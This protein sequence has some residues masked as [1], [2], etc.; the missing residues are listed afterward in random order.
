VVADGSD[1]RTPQIVSEFRNYGVRLLFH[2]R[3]EGKT[4]ALNRAVPASSGEILLFSDANTY[5]QPDTIEKLT[6][7]FNDPNV[8]GVS[9]RKIVL[10]DAER[11]ATEGEAAYW[12]YESSLK[13]WESLLGSIVTA[14]GEIFA[15]R[16]SLFEPIPPKTVHDDMYLTLRIIEQGYRV[17]YENEAISGEHASRTLRD[18]FH[19]KVRY[20]SAGYQIIA[21]FRHMLLPPRR[22][23]AVEFIFHKVCRWMMPFFLLGALLS[24]AII[25]PTFYQRMFW[26]QFAF[27]SI[28]VLGWALHKKVHSFIL[29]FPLYFL[30][31]NAA[32][33]CGFARHFATG[34]TTL[35]RKAE[36]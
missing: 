15:M 13:N 26:L 29:H 28:A 23:F 33:L 22:W 8:G 11:E 6:R 19:L 30:M 14:D 35:W 18:E 10:K 16:R 24:S 36:R 5:Y 3:R 20:V 9:G 1:D 21:S 7:N 27:Y 34:Q 4:A 31:A 17:V 12:S 25:Q 2:P 32:A